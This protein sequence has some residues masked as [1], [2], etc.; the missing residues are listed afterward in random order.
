MFSQIHHYF[1]IRLP[2]SDEYLVEN[3]I[4]SDST[5]EK[6]NT[7]KMLDTPIKVEDIRQDGIGNCYMLVVLASIIEACPSYLNNILK[8]N[9]AGFVEVSLYDVNNIN[10]K[11]IYILDPTKVKSEEMNNHK[12]DAI[13]LLEKAYAIHR[14]ISQQA[15]YNEKEGE[16]LDLLKEN[17]MDI[18]KT[19]SILLPRRSN[20]NKKN[21][22]ET[23]INSKEKY[24]RNFK[25]FIQ[26]QSYNN[27]E[28]VILKMLNANNMD[29]EVTKFAIKKD[30]KNF[31]DQIDAIANKN[32][33]TVTNEEEICRIRDKFKNNSSI[34]AQ[35]FT[36]EE[37]KIL[38]ILII[39][40]FYKDKTIAAMLFDDYFGYDEKKILQKIE[41][42]EQKYN[43][44]A[45]LFD[46]QQIHPYHNEEF[47]ILTILIGEDFNIIKTI[48]AISNLNITIDNS[49]KN[50]GDLKN[51]DLLKKIREIKEKYNHNFYIFS[52]LES[53]SSNEYILLLE[54]ID[55]NFNMDILVSQ[56]IKNE[57][58]NGQK[59]KLEVIAVKKKHDNNYYTY[60]AGLTSGYTD[61]VYT[62]FLGREV[63]CEP[64][65]PDLDA[66]YFLTNAN[67]INIMFKLFNDNEVL[68]A[69]IFIVS[70]YL[71]KHEVTEEELLKKA[72]KDA[73]KEYLNDQINNFFDKVENDKITAMRVERAIGPLLLNA[74]KEDDSLVK[75]NALDEVAKLPESEK[76]ILKDNIKQKISAFIEK[77]LPHK[78]GL[79]KYTSSQILTYQ[80][81]KKMLEENKL[82]SISTKENIGPSENPVINRFFN[83]IR[84]GLVSNH[85]YHVVNCYERNGLK[86][87]LIRN[88]WGKCERDYQLA[89]KVIA[90]NKVNVLSAYGRNYIIYSMSDLFKT[91]SYANR[92]YITYAA[93]PISNADLARRYQNN[94]YFE[95]EL[96]DF[97]KRFNNIYSVRKPVDMIS[98]NNR[99][100]ANGSLSVHK[101]ISSLINYILIYYIKD[102]NATH[103]KLMNENETKKLADLVSALNIFIQENSSFHNEFRKP[104][105]ALLAFYYH[106]EIR[107][108]TN[109]VAQSK[110]KVALEM[111]LNAGKISN[112]EEAFYY[113]KN[114]YREILKD[115]I[116]YHD[117]LKILSASY[118]LDADAS[119]IRY[120]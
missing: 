61:L 4:V 101:K 68:W 65:T 119:Q 5:F 120:A 100:I 110:N 74:L 37:S 86:F 75:M 43:N 94:G 107:K 45:S 71:N 33:S 62:S 57:N 112:I 73:V 52:Q 25:I 72:P 105:C 81:I 19:L 66:K 104:A 14:I 38:K 29:I 63:K 85:A 55:N 47:K 111:Y 93:L 70:L 41:Q 103:Y 46:L 106:F 2:I 83:G 20:E 13:F 44:N 109:S 82:I 24:D 108:E 64:I 21:F 28:I 1:D 77:E 56:F 113:L 22:I 27:E 91:K 35:S 49:R 23:L 87:I 67:F 88:P 34:Q 18:E 50:M 6:I 97:I 58:N 98:P 90:N 80:K 118:L 89:E 12:H 76:K 51:K 92:T 15:R 99:S 84:K 7:K 48:E 16:I 39:N 3:H 95:V 115:Y 116:L 31:N 8:I 17:E 59:I 9:K 32:Q 53:Y 102:K 26:Q 78:R 30:N 54:L 79:G 60:T 36:E 42:V 10:K 40:Q 117:E 11:Y 96:C 114:E 69:K